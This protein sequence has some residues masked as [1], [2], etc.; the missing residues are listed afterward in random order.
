MLFRHLITPDLS[1][2][3]ANSFEAC[4]APNH[5]PHT[6]NFC[7]LY[8]FI[9]G[10]CSYMVESGIFDL[11]PGTVIFTRPGEL[12]SV[13]ILESCS[14]SRIFYQFRPDFLK[15]PKMKFLRC[16]YNRP[17]GEKNALVLSK[18]Q[19]EQY[20]S[21]VEQTKNRFESHCIDASSYALADFLC[22]LSL[23]N[24]SFDKFSAIDLP[25]RCSQIVSS[26]LSYINS[27]LVEIK[28][29]DDVAQ[30]LFVSREYLSRRFTKEMGLTLNRYIA[31]KRVAAAQSLLV[32]GASATDAALQSG[33]ENYSYFIQ[34]F[35]RE[36]ELTPQEWK[37]L[38]QAQVT[39][40]I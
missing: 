7:E 5:Y 24:E 12:H 3:Y 15:L 26:A 1:I 33:F 27:H 18:E 8:I 17:F 29:T 2:E 39:H 25:D 14:Y 20:I 30:A 32:S 16:F 36:T 11:V 9:T 40:L 4:G 13:K 28:T 38:P 34:I 23:I 37:R 6:H 22:N 21:R 19:T 10:K 35:K 31:K